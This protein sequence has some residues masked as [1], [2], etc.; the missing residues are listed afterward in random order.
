M[1]SM[2]FFCFVLNSGSYLID[3]RS[4]SEADFVFCEAPNEHSQTCLFFFLAWNG[5]LSLRR[6]HPENELCWQ[7]E[8]ES[9][10]EADNGR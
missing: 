2:G 8:K 1:S 9:Y 3:L 10:S 6:S 7:R 4:L 5:G